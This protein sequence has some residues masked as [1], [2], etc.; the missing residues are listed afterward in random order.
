MVEIERNW[1]AWTSFGWYFLE[2]SS[3]KKHF[4]FCLNAR[5]TNVSTEEYIHRKITNFC[6]KNLFNKLKS[7]VIMKCHCLGFNLANIELHLCKQLKYFRAHFFFF[8]ASCKLHFSNKT[9]TGKTLN[10]IINAYITMYISTQS[11]SALFFFFLLI[12]Y[13]GLTMRMLTFS[14]SNYKRI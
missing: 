5:F 7:E 12:V 14:L 11:T 13:Y 1:F 3:I 10:R 8:F 4:C 9:F 2:Q 6:T